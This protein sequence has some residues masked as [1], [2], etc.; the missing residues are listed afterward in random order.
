MTRADLESII[1]FSISA[2]VC[3]LGLAIICSILGRKRETTFSLTLYVI[4]CV[5][6]F[7]ARAYAKQ[8]FPF[9][10]KIESFVT[11]SF[12]IVICALIYRNRIANK[13]F[14]A[15]L[16]LA[17]ASAGVSFIFEDKLH[18]PTAYLRTIWYPL[19]VPLSFAAYAL[20]LL[21][22]IDSLF[23]M[24]QLKTADP[25]LPDRPLVTELNR[26]GFILFS[27]AMLFGGIWGYLAWGA[28][29]MWDSKL[30]WS[31]ILWLY[32]GNLLHIDSLPRFRGWKVPLYIIGIALILITFI[33]TGFFTRSIHKF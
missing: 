31:V 32:Y 27:L 4:L 15:L 10:D 28:Y 6:F 16:I 22:G 13:E 9:T 26:N 7:S 24:K 25:D 30:L 20:W 23:S 1:F 8:F 21:A 19:H 3:F 29:F 17:L 12:L 5:L 2:A 14:T 11:L 18:Y 33:G